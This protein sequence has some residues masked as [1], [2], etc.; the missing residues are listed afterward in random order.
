[1]LVLSVLSLVFLSF[2][3]SSIDD[4]AEEDVDEGTSSIWSAKWPA[5][6]SGKERVKRAAIRMSMPQTVVGK[7]QPRGP[8]LYRN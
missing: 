4:V 3:C 2:E 6:V 1:M 7:Y 5:L 8:L